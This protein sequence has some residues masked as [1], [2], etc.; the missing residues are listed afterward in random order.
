MGGIGISGLGQIL[1][2]QGNKVTG[3]DPDKTPWIDDMGR[4]GISIENG[5]DPSHIHDVDL[6]IYS[7]A[8]PKNHP[9]LECARKQGIKVLSYPEALGELTKKMHSILVSGTHGK[10]TVTAMLAKIFTEN[11]L[12]PTVIVGALL[13]EF[14]H[15]NF[16]TGKSE[17]L[18][19]EACEYRRAFLK[20]QP[21]SLV[22]T[23]M[24]HD[25][26]DTYF[27]FDEYIGAFHSLAE[28]L[29]RSGFL[30]VNSDDENVMDIAK[31]S[32]ALVVP[33]GKN[34]KF[35]KIEGLNL[36]IPGEHNR[37]NALTA[38]TV[39]KTYKIPEEG[40]LKSLNS[41]RGASRRMEFL[42]EIEGVKLYDDYG[43][44]PTEIKATISAIREK[45]PK[46]KIC[47][48]FQPHQFNRTK[49]LLPEFGKSF[50]G[51]DEIIVPDIY[52]ARDSKEDVQDTSASQLVSE[53]SKHHPNVHDGG[54]LEKTAEELKKRLHEFDLI[55][56]MGAGDVWKVAVILKKNNS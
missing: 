55:L 36:Q 33:F 35:S 20:Y 42:G 7:L 41:Y 39:A 2:S 27:T 50:D 51:V 30:F 9:E 32:K 18:I 31:N 46:E 4:S 25:H 28:K 15:K 6:V 40:I 37:K 8:V 47:L 43:H 21:S 38:Y 13:P 23:N 14:G 1:I 12:D 34:G 29:P 11:G 56:I 54:G 3:C 26:F 53:I 17:Y 19:I 44:H 22:I 5:H 45:Y 52:F 48:V 49:H 16:R 24:E 10:T